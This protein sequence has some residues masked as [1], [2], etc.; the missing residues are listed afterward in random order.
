MNAPIVL[1]CVLFACLGFV[2]P[3]RTYADVDDDAGVSTPADASTS[4]DSGGPLA[5]DGG[6]CSTSTGGTFCT[7]T[8]ISKR[9]PAASFSVA[10]LFASAAI[11]MTR[12]SRRRP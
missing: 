1:R 12:L 2:A 4:D 3:S 9:P 6:L 5:C 11:L 7:V 10:C 8:A